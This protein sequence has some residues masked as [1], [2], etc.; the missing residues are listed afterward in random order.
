[1]LQANF[2]V[3]GNPN[4]SVKQ[5]MELESVVDT[6]NTLHEAITSTE[7][8]NGS[9]EEPMLQE[10]LQVDKNQNVSI[11]ESR[12]PRRSL[13]HSNK[14][15]ILEVIELPRMVITHM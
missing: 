7:Q 14:I 12:L 2:E 9:V 6:T 1:M 4:V 15:E 11:K 8:S 10:N 13:R 3:N 5:S